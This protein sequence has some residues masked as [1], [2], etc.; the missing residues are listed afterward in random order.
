LYMILAT[1]LPKAYKELKFS[2]KCENRDFPLLKHHF[3]AA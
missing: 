1:R 2:K 3:V